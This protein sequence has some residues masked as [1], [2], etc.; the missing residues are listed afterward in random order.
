VDTVGHCGIPFEGRG[1][2]RAR[3]Q[4]LLRRMHD[5]VPSRAVEDAS[6]VVCASNPGSFRASCAKRSGDAPLAG[7]TTK[8]MRK[9]MS[10]SFRTAIDW[11][12]KPRPHAR[13]ERQASSVRRPLEEPTETKKARSVV[14]LSRDPPLRAEF[15]GSPP[16]AGFYFDG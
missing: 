8:N 2:S 9:R 12:G 11:K 1:S 7:Q 15:A 10:L 13:Q 6:K 3:N 14:A 16:A 4:I 5:A